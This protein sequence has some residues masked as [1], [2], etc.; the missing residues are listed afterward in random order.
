MMPR[1]SSSGW[2]VI[3]DYLYAAELGVPVDRKDL[4][5]QHPDL[6]KHLKAFFAVGHRGVSMPGWSSVYR[7]ELQRLTIP[8][9]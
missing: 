5:A 1:R 8:A 3:A 7:S 2:Q 9:P 4:I 6:A